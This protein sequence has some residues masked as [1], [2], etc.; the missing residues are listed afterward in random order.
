MTAAHTRWGIN[1]L[2]VVVAVIMLI[3]WVTWFMLLAFWLTH[4]TPAPL[5]QLPTL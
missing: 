3:Q 5:G 2:G 1:A 4:Q